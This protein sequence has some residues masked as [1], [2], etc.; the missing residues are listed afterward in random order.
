MKKSILVSVIVLIGLAGTLAQAGVY[1]DVG[2]FQAALGDYDIV[3]F[4]DVPLLPAPRMEEISGGRYLESH[5]LLIDSISYGI[6]LRCEGGN[7]NVGNHY[8]GGSLGEFHVTF[9]KAGL[10][11]TIDGFGCWF[12][13]VDTPSR[14]GIFLYDAQDNY[15]GGGY[16]E[17]GG[18]NVWTFLG[19]KTPDAAYA[20]VVFNDVPGGV[21]MDDYMFSPIVAQ[22]GTVATF[23]DLIAHSYVDDAY[24]AKGALFS[25]GYE[26]GIYGEPGIGPVVGSSPH[27]LAVFEQP[28]R[29]DFVVP[30]TDIPAVT[31]SVSVWM[32]DI[33]VGTLLGTL[34]AYDEN[35]MALAS[36]VMDTPACMEGILEVHADDIAYVLVYADADGSS[37]DNVNFSVP[38]P[39]PATLGL[40][41]LGGLAL[42]KRRRKSV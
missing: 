32:S 17:A 21:I 5:G 24:R 25:P 12:G 40:F 13:D 36:N 42:L 22:T 39:E 35:N 37:V 1:R 23:D 33:E 34:V 30:G 2:R 19:V 26:V 18:D 11:T 38:V 28:M 9:S 15:L 16:V 27:A 7:N 20:R 4:D 31:D 41:L 10:P 29:I 6:W 14:S 8:P 3:D